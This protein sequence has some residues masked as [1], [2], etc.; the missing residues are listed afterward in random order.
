MKVW[1]Q[2]SDSG[3]SDYLQFLFIITPEKIETGLGNIFL[4]NSNLQTSWCVIGE[5]AD[6]IYTEGEL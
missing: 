3:Y 5:Q 4:G 2:R 6:C 1:Q